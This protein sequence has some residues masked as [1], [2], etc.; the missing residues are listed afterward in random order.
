VLKK[1]QELD[2]DEDEQKMNM[3]ILLTKCLMWKWIN[4]KKRSSLLNN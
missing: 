1:R 2:V 4:R 3:S